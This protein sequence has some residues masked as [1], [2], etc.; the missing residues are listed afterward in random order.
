MPTKQQLQN[1][2][3]TLQN[4]IRDTIRLL[5]EQLLEKE[6]EVADLKK[7]ISDISELIKN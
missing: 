7:Q 2:L 5:Q 1:S 4:N 6:A 3:T